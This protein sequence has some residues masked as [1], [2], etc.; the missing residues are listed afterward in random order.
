VFTRYCCSGFGYSDV[1]C[2]GVIHSSVI[3]AVLVLAILV[4]TELVVCFY[5]SLSKAI[6][7][8]MP[9]SVCDK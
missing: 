4:V 7:A 9:K 8:D 6:E 1:G 3:A 2:D 5:L